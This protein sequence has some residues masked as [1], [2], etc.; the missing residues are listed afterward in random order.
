MSYVSSNWTGRTPRTTQEAS[1]PHARSVI[2]EPK[3]EVSPVAVVLAIVYV[4]ALVTVWAV[5]R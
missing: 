1:N 3:R 2:T 5:T 4:V